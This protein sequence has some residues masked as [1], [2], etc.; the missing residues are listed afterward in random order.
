MQI[1]Q[2]YANYAWREA[3]VW[4]EMSIIQ[5]CSA[6]E[7][8][9]ITKLRFYVAPSFSYRLSSSYDRNRDQNFRRQARWL[10][11]EPCPVFATGFKRIIALE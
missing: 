11:S 9:Q 1:M 7:L 5:P 4:N 8:M 3:S 2:K 6:G 10:L